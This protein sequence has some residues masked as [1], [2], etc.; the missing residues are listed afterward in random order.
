MRRLLTLALMGASCVAGPALA[1]P[2]QIAADA[3]WT[4]IQR[5]ELVLIDVR[6]P[7]E[8]AMT[9]LPRDAHVATLQDVD[10]IAQARGAV[11][12]DLDQPVAVIC[13]SGAR[14]GKAASELEQ[15]GFTH[16]FDVTEGMSGNESSGEGWIKRGL[17]VDPFIPP[18][19]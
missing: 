1:D 13:R 10:F 18:D 17:P 14:S 8:W 7:S 11:L 12:G 9:G 4:L 15:A 5:G 6:T 2:E 19:R 16:V 3:A